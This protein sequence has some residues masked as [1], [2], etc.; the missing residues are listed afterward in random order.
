M[1]VWGIAFVV[2]A[3][4]KAS[5]LVLV[6]ATAVG[7]LAALVAGS[8]APA[9]MG[10]MSFAALPSTQVMLCVAMMIAGLATG[11]SLSRVE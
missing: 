3:H 8:V 5:A 10:A 7:I 4:R 11:R 9:A 1:I 6:L 2:V